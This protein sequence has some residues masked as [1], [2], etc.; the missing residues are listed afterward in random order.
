MPFTNEELAKCAER[1]VSILRP[2]LETI[3][4]AFMFD[5]SDGQ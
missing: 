2:G 1:E 4:M 5:F 3:L